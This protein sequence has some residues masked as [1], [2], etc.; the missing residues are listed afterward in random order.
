MA[1]DTELELQENSESI[2]AK[3]KTLRKKILEANNKQF[4]KLEKRIKKQGEN[5]MRMA[6]L[7]TGG[8][9]QFG[10]SKFGGSKFGGSKFG[11]SVHNQSH[12]GHAQHH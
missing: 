8:L 6:G 10:G 7:P 11:G 5:I 2:D 4:E 9:S 12:G 3:L 1:I